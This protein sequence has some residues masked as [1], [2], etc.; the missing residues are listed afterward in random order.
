[1]L[2]ILVAMMAERSGSASSRVKRGRA[3]RGRGEVRGQDGGGAGGVVV[4][5]N[6]CAGFFSTPYIIVFAN[7][8]VAS[9]DL[10]FQFGAELFYSFIYS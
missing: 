1:M 7:H 9:L 4:V 3:W 6:S 5:Q 8:C 2:A 10:K